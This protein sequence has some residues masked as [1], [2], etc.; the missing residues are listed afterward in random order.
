[1]TAR[2]QI[3][4]LFPLGLLVLLVIAGLRGAVPAPGWNGPLR[5]YGTP[6]GIGLEVLFGALLIVIRVRAT[7]ARRAAERRVYTAEM[8]D[9]EPADALRYT[10][11]YVLGPCMIAIAVVLITNLHL[12]FFTVRRK[13]HPP[14]LP[15]LKAP[16]GSG[17][18]VGGLRT[19][20][21]PIGPILYGLLVVALVAAVAIS[22]WWSTRLRRPAAPLVIEDVSTEELRE[23]VA[24]GRAAL[25]GIDDARAAIIACYVAMERSLGDRGTAR[26]AADTPDELLARAVAAGVVRGGAA[27]RLT[28]LFYEA[29]FSTHPLGG[30]Q[31]DA[32]SA[33]LDEIAAELAARGS[34]A[35]RPEAAGQAGTAQAGTGQAGAGQAG[36]PGPGQQPKPGGGWV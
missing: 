34:A 15:T 14:Q 2:Q 33:A 16:R 32:A 7:A 24:E 22:I 3:A 30:G 18:P 29:R 36:Q 10:L 1:V 25:A 19:F 27:G 11:T 17:G 4:R 26:A 31:R 8:Q 12:H 21:I 20:N 5:S 35:P 23:A 9:I 13:L 28:A 6:I